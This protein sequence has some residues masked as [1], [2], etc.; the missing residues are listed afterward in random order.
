MKSFVKQVIARLS[1]D[2]AEVT[3]QKNYR[4]ASS[5]VKSQLAALEAKLVDDEVKLEEAT[6][7]LDN[8]KFPTLSI[9]NNQS[10]VEKIRDAQADV[11]DAE[12]A[13]KQTQESIGYFQ[14]LQAEFDA[15]AV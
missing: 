7:A 4:K 8:A 3:A 6:E 10:Y 12:E 11:E 14:K 5:A 15:E 2:E 13:L 9:S 1:G